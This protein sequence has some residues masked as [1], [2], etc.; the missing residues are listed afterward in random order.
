MKAEFGGNTVAAAFATGNCSSCG[1]SLNISLA[2][3]ANSAGVGI[4]AGSSALESSLE[5]KL[6]DP[7][8]TFDAGVG[9][10]VLMV[11][12]YVYVLEQGN[13]IVRQHSR[14]AVQR[15]EVRGKRSLINPHE[16]N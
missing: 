6:A 16:A 1:N 3:R 5:G 12:S 10:L 8:V 9:S 2:S 15:H 13:C 11:L 4:P 7:G 14:R